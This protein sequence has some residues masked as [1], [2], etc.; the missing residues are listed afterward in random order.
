MAYMNGKKILNAN[1]ILAKADY[2]LVSNALKGNK[3]GETVVLDDVSPLEHNLK[4]KVSGG[5]TLR[6]CGKNILPY[7]YLENESEVEGITY[8]VNSDGSITATG[9][10]DEKSTSMWYIYDGEPLVTSGKVYIQ[11]TSNDNNKLQMNLQLY[12]KNGTRLYEKTSTDSPAP[13]VDLDAYGD[14]VAKWIILVKTKNYNIDA[15]GTY[16]PMI[17]IGETASDYEPYVEPITYSVNADGT[18]EGVTSIYPTTVLFTDT[19]GVTIEAEYNRDINKS[20]GEWRTIQHITLAEDTSTIVFS[21]DSEGNPFNLKKARLI[22]KGTATNARINFKI[23]N[24]EYVNPYFYTA[25]IAN[26]AVNLVLDIGEATNGLRVIRSVRSEN[27]NA[28]LIAENSDLLLV[29]KNVNGEN[30]PINHIKFDCNSSYFFLSGTEIIFE[31][32]DEK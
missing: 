17:A 27:S 10:A 14:A 7:P 21:A 20:L 23:N 2:T 22:I 30:T 15:T 31:G 32:V 12:D 13:I 3:S 5:T 9:T 26:K 24:G 19:E 29:T 11:L 6:K 25:M 18:V 28:Y 16:F 4:V 8:T 1:V